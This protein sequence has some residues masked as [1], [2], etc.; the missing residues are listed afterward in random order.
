MKIKQ[1]LCFVA[2]IYVCFPAFQWYDVITKQFDRLLSLIWELHAI[3]VAVDKL[4]IFTLISNH[5]EI[6]DN[7]VVVQEAKDTMGD[8]MSS[9]SI[10]YID[11][12]CVILKFI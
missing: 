11:S 1:S 5:T 10:P 12:M 2:S 7:T 8:Q 4:V 9:S 3:L 6:H